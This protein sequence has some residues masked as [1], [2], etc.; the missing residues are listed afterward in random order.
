MCVTVTLI[1]LDAPPEVFSP[2]PAESKHTE[3]LRKENW[4]SQ[5]T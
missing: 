5:K 1:G 4:L 3:V 2:F